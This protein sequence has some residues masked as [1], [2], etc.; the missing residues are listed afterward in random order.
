M[1]KLELLEADLVRDEG[2][3]LHAYSDSLG[4]WTIGVGRLIDAR[5]GGGISREESR[6]LLQND[7]KAVLD[8]LLTFPWYLG[9]DGVRKRAIANMRFQ[10]GGKTFRSF[11]ATL[12]A[13]EAGDYVKAADQMRKSKWYTQT[14]KRCERVARMIATGDA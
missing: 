12:A 13:I 5:K 6:Y 2:E 4:Y 11:K 1:T 14:P 10:L 8:D 3:C 7:I 9:L